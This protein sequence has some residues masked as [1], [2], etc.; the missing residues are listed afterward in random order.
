MFGIVAV[1][2]GTTLFKEE[3]VYVRETARGISCHTILMDTQNAP[4]QREW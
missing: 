2:Q 1:C 4:I 3:D